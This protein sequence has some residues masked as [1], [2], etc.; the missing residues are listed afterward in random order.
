[1]FL[2]RLFAG[3]GYVLVLAVFYFLKILL[4]LIDGVPQFVGDFCFDA[5]IYALTLIGT[6]EMLRAMQGKICKAEKALVWAFAIITIPLCAVSS[7]R[8]LCLWRLLWRCSLP[9]L[10]TTKI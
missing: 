2:K 5:A 8:R 10:P 1:M 6:F 3:A 4:P 7:G 9:L